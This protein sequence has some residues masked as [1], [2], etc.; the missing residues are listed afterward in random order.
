MSSRGKAS[1]DVKFSGID[2]ENNTYVQHDIYNSF[3]FIYDICKNL[4]LSNKKELK[5]GQKPTKIMPFI[6]DFVFKFKK[7][8]DKLVN[9]HENDFVKKLCQETINFLKTALDIN[10]N[11]QKDVI[12]FVFETNDDSQE[13]SFGNEYYN[14]GLRLFFPL[15]RAEKEVI[16]SKEIR[17]GYTAHLNKYLSIDSETCENIKN[18]IFVSKK[19]KKID[20]WEKFFQLPNDTVPFYGCKKEDEPLYEIRGYFQDQGTVLL[21]NYELIEDQICYKK[22]SLF[23]KEWNS[24]EINNILEN[25]YIILKKDTFDDEDAELFFDD[26]EEKVKI[27]F[28]PFI[29][30]MNFGGKKNTYTLCTSYLN[31]IKKEEDSIGVKNEVEEITILYSLLKFLK[32]IRFEKSIIFKEIGKIIFFIYK[33]REI[34]HKDCHEEGLSIWCDIK[35][36]Y[37][38]DLGY[39]KITKKNI[40][41]DN[42]DLLEYMS[43]NQDKLKI[44][45]EDLEECFTVDE[46][47]PNMTPSSGRSSKVATE[48]EF[49]RTLYF[50]FE[51][52]KFITVRTIGFYAKKDNPS[53]YKKWHE[54][55]CMEELLEMLRRPSELTIS[56]CF[57][58]YN[59]LFLVYKSEKSF[60]IYEETIHKFIDKTTNE[61]YI[62]GKLYTDFLNDMKIIIDKNRSRISSEIYKPYLSEVSEEAEFSSKKEKARNID[63]SF[64]EITKIFSSNS[65]QN[66]IYGSLCSSSTIDDK[67]G[68]GYKGCVDIEKVLDTNIYITGVQN[69]V[70]EIDPDMGIAEF[71][72][73]KPEDFITFSSDISFDRSYSTGHPDMVSFFIYMKTVFPDN[74]IRAYV[75]KILSSFLLRK[76]LEKKIYYIIGDTNG[77][78]S[79]L[80]SIISICLGSYAAILGGEMLTEKTKAGQ[81]NTTLMTLKNASVALI[82]EPDANTKQIA[83]EIKKL[84]GGDNMQIRDMR[85]KAN[86]KGIESCFK[87][88]VACNIIP[89][90]SDHDRASKERNAFI[91][92]QSEF[93]QSND[94]KLPK[95]FEERMEKRIFSQETDMD[96]K[97]TT[98]AKAMLWYMV[99]CYAAYSKEPL[100]APKIIEEMIREHWRINDHLMGFI[101][102]CLERD[103]QDS[104]N[105]D[106]FII[107][108]DLYE[109]YS[110][111]MEKSFPSI[112]E[113]NKE[114][115]KK[116][117]FTQLIKCAD[118]LG[119]CTRKEID[120]KNCNVWKY[121]SYSS[122]FLKYKQEKDN[123]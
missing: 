93:V 57:L 60:I 46:E 55:F 94:K 64:A 80:I 79:V 98:L 104:E 10:K 73:G 83:S 84:T 109:N 120:G 119:K 85:E 4:T 43:R 86:K 26:E 48:S 99:K 100:K 77:S 81:Q 31:E 19:N 62:K 92:A 30:T 13:W 61:N 95:S 105:E 115:K 90:L 74:D 22:H 37:F 1:D 66:K 6:F 121:Y 71:R 18:N 25:E 33:K 118:K 75:Y 116:Q 108:S 88:L 16:N 68:Y 110:I 54:N 39:D 36:K 82:S 89:P 69:G 23:S 51:T 101:D 11:K 44:Q 112:D 91:P 34:F 106:H 14:K 111:W 78:K 42:G 2:Y 63:I 40:K 32:P 107:E 7:E 59:W 38:K 20:E 122:E 56:K 117:E 58:K 8:E 17:K 72:D 5:Y 123:V 114:K 35:N 70:I 97:K 76:N 41:K 47:L 15:I 53:E 3:Q 65:S 27:N 102:E 49:L 113:R 52:E 29:F 9:I 24:D 12:P 45:D 50:S 21:D 103:E 28:M 87:I 67:F 96:K